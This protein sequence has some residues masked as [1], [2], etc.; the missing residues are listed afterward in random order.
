MGEV[1]KANGV[2]AAEPEEAGELNAAANPAANEMAVEEGMENQ[3]MVAIEA[4]AR[5]PEAATDPESGSIRQSKRR[6][7]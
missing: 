5:K 7:T 3:E 2:E 1:L 4:M 6:C